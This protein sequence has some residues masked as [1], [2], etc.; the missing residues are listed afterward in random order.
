[1]T[2]KWPGGS[3]LHVATGINTLPSHA[4]FRLAFV[5]SYV[6]TRRFAQ[7]QRRFIRPDEAT[8]N[9]IQE[10]FSAKAALSAVQSKTPIDAVNPPR[11]T[12][13]PPLT[14]P[15]RSQAQTVVIY[16]WQIGKAYGT[17]YKEGVKA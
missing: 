17:F 6:T 4:T 1:M 15:E 7:G 2:A 8:K 3:Y 5:G 10:Q 16:W 11:S 14:L 13:P 12:L 9:A